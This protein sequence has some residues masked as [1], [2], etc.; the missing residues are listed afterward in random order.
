MLSFAREYVASGLFDAR[1][2]YGKFGTADLAI[3]AFV[4]QHAEEPAKEIA[5]LHTALKPEGYLALLDDGKRFVPSGVDAQ[6]YVIWQ[7][8]GITVE[9]LIA[10]KFAL[11]IRLPYPNRRD[12]PLSIWK[13]I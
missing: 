8:D 2:T 11:I 6:G 3:A 13:K 7:D 4:L 10:E 12:L 9:R 1:A 5:S